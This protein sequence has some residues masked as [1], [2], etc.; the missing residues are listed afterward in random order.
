MEESTPHLLTQCNYIEA[1]W[2]R[3]AASFNLPNF[4]KLQSQEGPHGWIQG[5]KGS[6]SCKEKRKMLGI[7]FT[8]WWQ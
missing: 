4:T 1:T 5:I 6:G 2:N 7:L 8:F 3:V